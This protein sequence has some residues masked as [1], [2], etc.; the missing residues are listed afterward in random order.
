MLD[1]ISRLAQHKVQMTHRMVGVAFHNFVC[2]DHM[3]G[4]SVH[5]ISKNECRDILFDVIPCRQGHH[6]KL[7][8]L[9]FILAIQVGILK[10][11]TISNGTWPTDFKIQK[12]L[13]IIDKSFN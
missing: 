13:F 7:G 8:E 9:F 6:A 10:Y 11:S 4:V 5:R 3:A 12:S 1:L 2:H